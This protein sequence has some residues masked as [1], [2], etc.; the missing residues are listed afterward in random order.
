MRH[1]KVVNKRNN[2][3][4]AKILSIHADLKGIVENVRLFFTCVL[5]I[6]FFHICT[7][8]SSR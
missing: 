1:G 5:F 4:V 6:H 8:F 2:L 7:I 3:V